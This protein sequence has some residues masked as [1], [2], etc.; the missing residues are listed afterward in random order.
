M[1]N[2]QPRTQDAEQDASTIATT[3][4]AG[5][6]QPAAAT[7]QEA[8]DATEDLDRLEP[9]GDTAPGDGDTKCQSPGTRS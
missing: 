6:E 9:H 4:N 8:H 2:C 1:S 7:M 3:A 5:L